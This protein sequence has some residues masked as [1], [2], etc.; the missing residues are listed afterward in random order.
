MFYVNLFDGEVR[1]ICKCDLYEDARFI[2]YKFTEKTP[3]SNYL[4]LYEDGILLASY[5]NGEINNFGWR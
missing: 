5:M 4:Y 2:F 3:S 1:T